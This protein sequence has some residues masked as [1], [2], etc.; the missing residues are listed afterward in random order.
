MSTLKSRSAPR[1]AS[2]GSQSG[3]NTTGALPH[4][5]AIPGGDD[6][7]GFDLDVSAPVAEHRAHMLGTRERTGGEVRVVDRE[8]LAAVRAHGH[9]PREHAPVLEE[10]ALA[11]VQDLDQSGDVANEDERLDVKTPRCV[12]SPP[13]R[14]PE[15]FSWVD[16]QEPPSS[17]AF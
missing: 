8:S 2:S 7:R 16:A 13:N 3:S 10:A 15:T 14:L 9:A 11:E 1:N 6:F 12:Q 17:R 5:A 4:L